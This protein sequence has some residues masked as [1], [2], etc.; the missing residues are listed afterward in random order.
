VAVLVIPRIQETTLCLYYRHNRLMVCRGTITDYGKY[1]NGNM[2]T[3]CGQ[4]RAFLMLKQLQYI[5]IYAV[6]DKGVLQG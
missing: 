4:Y 2:T 6:F 1:R 3:L 5:R